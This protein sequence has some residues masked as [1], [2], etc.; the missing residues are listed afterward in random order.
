MSFDLIISL[1]IGA[2]IALLFW[3]IYRF[4]AEVPDEDRSYLD[5]PAVGFRVLWPLIRSGSHYLSFMVSD[6][7]RYTTDLRLKRAGMQYQINPDQFFSS[8]VIAAIATM[9]FAW[10]LFSALDMNSPGLI[11]IFGIGG[12]YYPELWLKETTG[13]RNNEI[14]KT[15]PFYLDVIT[16]AVESGSS[17]TIGI[18]KAIQKAPEGHLRTEFGRVLRDIR[19]GKPRSDALREMTERVSSEGLS[20]VVSSMIQAEKT[21]ASLGPVLRA[22]SDQLRTTRF[23]KA[24]KMAMEAPVKLLGPLIMF[25]FPTTFIVIGFVILT[26]VLYQGLISWG[27]LIWLFT[28]P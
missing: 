26:K 23:L 9:L 11:L 28:N 4:Y 21:G 24:E 27:P 19:A 2:F 13:K 25:I 6:N 7:Y 22:Q 16:L 20:N 15:L 17:L 12:F 1:M 8:K 14:F 3:S 18:S 5:R 10:M